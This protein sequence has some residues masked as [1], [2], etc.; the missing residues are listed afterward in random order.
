MFVIL[1][2]AEP[3]SGFLTR[4][5]NLIWQQRL[6]VVNERAIWFG[7]NHMGNK[8]SL[9]SKPNELKLTRKF[10]LRECRAVQNFA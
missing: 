7:F 4:F 10:R 2:K 6:K 1:N 3:L 5:A 8:F 9:S